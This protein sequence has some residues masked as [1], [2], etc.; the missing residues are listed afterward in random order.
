MFLFHP[1]H[2]NQ[3]ALVYTK[4]FHATLGI[5]LFVSGSLKAI[6]MVLSEKYKWI[7]YGWILCLFIAS[8][9]LITYNEPEG[10][11]QMSSW[12]QQHQGKMMLN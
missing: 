11:Y 3:E 5:V 7:T 2:G 6:E 12:K 4:P 10:A 8:I 9:M 1:Q